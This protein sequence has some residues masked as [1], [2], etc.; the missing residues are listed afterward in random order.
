MHFWWLNQY[1][2]SYFRYWKE[3]CQIRWTQLEI[4]FCSP[5]DTFFSGNNVARFLYFGSNDSSF[6]AEYN[7]T[8]HD[9]HFKIIGSR[10][11]PSSATCV[12][13]RQNASKYGKSR[14]FSRWKTE[15]LIYSSTRRAKHHGKNEYKWVEHHL[16]P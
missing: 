6:Q 12:K 16:A 7:D 2:L 13:M 14:F 10:L 15:M 5:I 4:C 9:G 3:T 1:F 8:H 11:A